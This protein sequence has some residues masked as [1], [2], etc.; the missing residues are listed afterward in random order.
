MCLGC[1]NVCG[2]FVFSCFIVGLIVKERLYV[3]VLLV[4]WLVG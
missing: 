4:F 3:V 1:I 2:G